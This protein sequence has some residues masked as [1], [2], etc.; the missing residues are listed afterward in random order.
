MSSIL[1]FVV[2]GIATGA[3]YGLAGSGLVLTYKTSGIFNFAHGAIAAAAAFIF[4]WLNVEHGW[5]W[6]PSMLVSVPVFGCV[7]GLLFELTARRLSRQRTA[8]KIVGTVSVVLLVQGLSTVKFGHNTLRLPQYLPKG[9]ETFRFGGVNITYAQLTIAIVA[10]VVVGA[11]YVLFYATRIGLEMRAV[12]D[13][14]ALLSIHGTSPRRVRRVAWLI[15]TMF[16]ALSGV[17]IAPSLGIEAIVLTY[18]VVQ[19]FGAAAMGWF[20][21]I[22]VTFGGGIVLGILSSLSTKYV[23]ETPWLRGLPL[24]LPFI[25]LIIV[26]IVLPRRKLA[27]RQGDQ[28]PPLQWQAPLPVQ[29]LGGAF[30]VGLLLFVPFVV[31]NKLSFVTVGVTQA[32]MI[33]SLGLLVRTA[34]M[35]SL[36]HAAF[37]AIGAVAFAQFV[38][39]FN[40]PWLL[41]VFVGALVVV[42]IAAV[43]ALPA[44]RL[45]GLFLALVTLGFGLMVER[46]FYSRSFMFTT[47]GDGR[48]MPRPSFAESDRAW[49]YV[50]VAFLLLA[51][52]AI[53][54]I[55]RSRLGR[56]VRGLSESTTAVT[57]LGLNANTT[58]IIVFCISG[59]MAGI[60][61]VLYGSSVHFAVFGDARYSSFH[62]LVLLVILAV[63]PFREPWYAIVAA[64]TA[65]IP[66]YWTSSNSTSWINVI[67]GVFG[68]MLAMQ[69]GPHTMPEG[70]RN[71]LSK[72]DVKRPTPA[73]AGA[74]AAAVVTEPE[75]VAAPTPRPAG[76]L[77]ISGVS[78]RFGGH[79]A[80]SSLSLQAPVGRITGLIGPNGAGKTTTFNACSGLLR[81]SSGT[82]TL[83]GVD[84][85]GMPPDARAR[86][87]LGRTF[88]IMQ[89][90]D[91][92]TVEQNVALGVESGMAGANVVRQLIATRADLRAAREATRQA[93]DL[94]GIG[95]LAGRQAG[96]LST[97]Q[98]RLVELARCIAGDFDV[99]LLDEPSSGLDNAETAKFGEVLTSVVR[100]R[101]CGVLLVEHDMQLVMEICDYIYVLDFG[102]LLFEGTQSEVADSP[103]VQAAYLGSNVDDIRELTK[104][105]A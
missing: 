52:G 15:G 59:F 85:S 40:M 66:G 13:D 54:A 20:S 49:Y 41:A 34:G 10:I 33:L 6:I 103:V 73:L 38:E 21:S 46:M 27:E 7:A 47:L 5:H 22:P 72:L 37:G 35:V 50:T 18:L 28:R 86:R 23:L 61:G 91:S 16:A 9:G 87:G 88:Q 102:Q 44:I 101:G 56:I 78:V 32:I 82:V 80:V 98:R 36:G 26:L 53:L 17:L 69:G 62:S 64:A 74:G 12:V 89:L 70:M 2:S 57:T 75:V 77:A 104:S 55:R 83:H 24:S 14:P 31:D 67:F 90:G 84:I 51:V 76:A 4:Y 99:L 1:P 71:L 65:V 43:L 94:V 97:G 3:V 68:V 29:L 42:P 58:R 93:M 105:R 8:M 45:T 95:D 63:T 48:K 30:G 92:L 96:A 11:L 79:L 19:A 39:N 25:V 100:Q 81:P 60:A